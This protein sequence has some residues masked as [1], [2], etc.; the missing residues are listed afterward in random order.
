MSM[1]CLRPI[2]PPSSTLSRLRRDQR[3][4][5]Q[6]RARRGNGR[7]ARSW[8]MWRMAWTKRPTAFL[9]PRRGGLLHE[10]AEEQQCLVVLLHA[11][12]F[13]FTHDQLPALRN[14][15]CVVSN[16]VAFTGEGKL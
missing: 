4:L 12:P 14:C 10:D 7:R 6:R 1:T 9:G 3:R 16:G 11:V 15:G 13:G 5:G 8:S 2:A